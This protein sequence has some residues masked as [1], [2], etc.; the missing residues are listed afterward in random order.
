M[1]DLIKNA[2]GHFQEDLIQGDTFDDIIEKVSLNSGLNKKA[3]IDHSVNVT[4]NFFMK[5]SLEDLQNTF[6]LLGYLTD[7]CR[8]NFVRNVVF[9]N[10]T[11][12][13]LFNAYWLFLL[14]LKVPLVL[15]N[16][17]KEPFIAS[18]LVDALYRAGLPKKSLYFLPIADN[19]MPPYNSGFF[20]DKK[21]VHFSD[22]PS[23]GTAIPP[24]CAYKRPFEPVDFF[25]AF[26][27][28]E[29]IASV[30]K[31]IAGLYI[32]SASNGLCSLKNVYVNNYEAQFAQALSKEIVRQFENSNSR[33]NAVFDIERGRRFNNAFK[34]LSYNFADLTSYY[35]SR[36]ILRKKDNR[37][38]SGYYYRPIVLLTHKYFEFDGETTFPYIAVKPADQGDF[39]GF[40]EKNR[41]RTAVLETHS[42]EPVHS[43][44]NV[45][46]LK[47]L[48]EGIPTM[49]RIITC[50]MGHLLKSVIAEELTV[51]TS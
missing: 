9:I 51:V 44:Q 6:P 39:A 47:C 1:L 25:I 35:Y 29:E 16:T 21:T 19:R 34:A 27:D 13:P 7:P 15:V 22:N 41:V 42:K 37:F 38:R 8:K 3:V 4:I 10:D 18:R 12:Y 5:G 48:I 28:K 45:A 17:A 32:A 30:A 20:E 36:D 46:S 50:E 40:A 14:L 49:D 24:N 33:E 31:K 23:S 11:R 26:R 2:L 43:L